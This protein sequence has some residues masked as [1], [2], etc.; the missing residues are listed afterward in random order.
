MCGGGAPED[1]SPEVA[2]IERDAARE[3]REFDRQQAEAARIKQEQD[4]ARKLA[5]FETKLNNAFSLGTGEAESFFRSRGLDPSEYGADIQREASQRRAQVPQLAGEVGS[6]FSGLGQSVYQNLT[7]ALRNRSMRALN[8]I[9]PEGFARQRIQDTADDEIINS[10]LADER[11]EAE[12]YAQNLFNRGVVTE[13][14]LAAA[15]ADIGKQANR[16][17]FT[18]QE[19]GKG[20]LEG[21]RGGAIN[22]VNQGRSRAS[23]L[24]L[25]E[26]FDPY[27]TTGTELNSFFTDFLQNLGN[28]FRAQAPT[29]LFDIKGLPVIAGAAQ[30]AQNTAFDPAAIAGVIGDERRD[31]E[32]EE[33]DVFDGVF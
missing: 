12:N 25:G 11:A 31:D 15:M 20:I 8:Q 3:Q 24:E 22:L 2:A 6:Y 1:R 9:A 14:G 17:Q 30:G 28:R 7:D 32:E 10:I 33:D 13:G 4:E 27:L 5:E 21:G 18:L 26:D 29:D 16:G 19:L 23:N